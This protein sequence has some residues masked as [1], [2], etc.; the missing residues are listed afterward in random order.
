M[1]P[2]PRRGG[3]VREYCY[4][5]R[6]NSIRSFKF[7]LGLDF[8]FFSLSFVALEPTGRVKYLSSSFFFLVQR[9]FHRILTIRFHFP[10]LSCTITGWAPFA[11]AGLLQAVL[12]VMCVFWKKRQAKLGIDDYGKPLPLE[13][14]NGEPVVP[15]DG[16]TEGN[17]A[18]R[19][20]GDETTPLLEN[21]DSH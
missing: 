19:L 2:E 16:D 4:S 1:H 11:A 5:V 15:R 20:D 9:R 13:G 17:G 10:L 14:S 7:R 18:I 6:L 21:S 12:L 3:H 8:A